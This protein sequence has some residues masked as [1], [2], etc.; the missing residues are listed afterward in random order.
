MVSEA[1]EE[2][3]SLVDKATETFREIAGD[4]VVTLFDGKRF[5]CHAVKGKLMQ[6]FAIQR[7]PRAIRLV[8]EDAKQKMGQQEEQLLAEQRLEGEEE[9]E[10]EAEAE[11]GNSRTG[12]FY[13]LALRIR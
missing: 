6:I 2:V 11:A 4:D 7:R 10:E 13:G 5:V 9:E 8:R 3:L 12:V 1:V